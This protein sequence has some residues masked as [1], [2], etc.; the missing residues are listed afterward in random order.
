MPGQHIVSRQRAKMRMNE[1]TNANDGL[2]CLTQS[3]LCTQS[4]VATALNMNKTVVS[5]KLVWPFT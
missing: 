3:G 2:V 5:V 1:C 4:T